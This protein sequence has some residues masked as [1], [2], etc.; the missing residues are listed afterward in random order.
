MEKFLVPERNL[1]KQDAFKSQRK[2]FRKVY[3][4]CP[5]IQG[6]NIGYHPSPA[7]DAI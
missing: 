7:Q 2:N 3:A 1:Q 6:P 4:S 5:H